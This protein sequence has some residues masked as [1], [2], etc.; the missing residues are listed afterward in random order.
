[1]TPNHVE[2]SGSTSGGTAKLAQPVF[3]VQLVPVVESN[4]GCRRT[5]FSV[6]TLQSGAVADGVGVTDVVE[7]TEA[8]TDVDA[9]GVFDG[10]TLIV[11]VSDTEAVSDDVSLSVGV[12]DEVVD[13]AGVRDDDG[14]L[15]G[16]IVTEGVTDGDGVTKFGTSVNWL[17]A[18][19]LPDASTARARRASN[20]SR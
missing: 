17:F 19:P 10:V 18:V 4:S 15:V 6:T 7:V 2:T 16:V 13:R 14:V 1:M 11:G 8:E 5:E 20:T 3:V 9:D 12:L